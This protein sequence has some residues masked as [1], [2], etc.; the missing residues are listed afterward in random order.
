MDSQVLNG[1]ISSNGI[2][3]NKRG[4]FELFARWTAISPLLKLISK[5]ELEKN[6]ITDPEELILLEIRDQNGFG[7][8]FNVTPETLS[9]WKKREKFWELVKAYQKKWG[10]DKTPNVIAGLYREA[11]KHGN[12]DRNA[13]LW[14]QYMEDWAPK[15]EVTV[16]ERK[17]I[18][19][20][21]K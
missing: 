17:L 20:D 9:R 7:A 6:G 21:E 4:E 15:E 1:E 2:K 12:K 11:V 3:L 8:K 5:G 18:V 13:Q 16:T 10:R 19:W 14:L